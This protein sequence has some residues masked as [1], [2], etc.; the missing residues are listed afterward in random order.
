[1]ICMVMEDEEHALFISRAH[2]TIRYQHRGLLLEYRTVKEILN[3]RSTE[4]I[5]RISKYLEEIENNMGNLGMK[6]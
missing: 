6:R 2:C 4:D 1:M 5:V 3:P